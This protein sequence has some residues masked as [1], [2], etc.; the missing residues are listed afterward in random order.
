MVRSLETGWEDGERWKFCVTG[1]SGGSSW[2]VTI[3]VLVLWGALGRMT[4]V[5]YLSLSLLW[6]IWGISPCDRGSIRSGVSL[7]LRLR[8]GHSLSSVLIGE[9]A[10]EILMESSSSFSSRKCCHDDKGKALISIKTVLKPTVHLNRTHHNS[11]E[12]LA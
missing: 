4:V 7:G 1:D 12:S 5:G 8:N 9:F 6:G 10:D 2:R 3:W 11:V